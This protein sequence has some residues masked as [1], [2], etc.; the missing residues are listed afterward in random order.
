MCINQ[1]TA[2][3]RKH[4]NSTNTTDS[5]NTI[6]S[7]DTFISRNTTV[8]TNT[9][10]LGMYSNSSLTNQSAISTLLV[11]T[12]TS[13]TLSRHPTATTTHPIHTSMITLNHT[14]IMEDKNLSITGCH[15]ETTMPVYAAVIIAVLVILLV[16]LVLVLIIVCFKCKKRSWAT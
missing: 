5:T 10:D 2:R 1:P 8:S 7:A 3:H 11:I 4:H 13:S 14:P 16:I 15:N 6:V 9:T 12:V